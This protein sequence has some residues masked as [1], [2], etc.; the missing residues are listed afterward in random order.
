[1]ITRANGSGDLLSRYLLHA[2]VRDGVDY[3]D[4]ISHVLSPMGFEEFLKYYTPSV[5][6][7]HFGFS[8]SQR[9]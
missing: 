5:S 4:C 6:S 2:S 8:Q 1:M 7:L 9:L 3:D